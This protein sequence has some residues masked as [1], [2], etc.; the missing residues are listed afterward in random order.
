MRRYILIAI[1][2]LVPMAVAPIEVALAQG[3]PSVSAG[4]DAL[5]AGQNQAAIEHFSAAIGSLDHADTSLPDAYVGR[6][7]AREKIG[8][9]E[10]AAEDF[11]KF[12]AIVVAD[13]DDPLVALSIALQVRAAMCE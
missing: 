8:E 5:R 4:I 12:L 11:D 7:C 13:F 10:L 3:R 9:N 1:V 6:S 2:L